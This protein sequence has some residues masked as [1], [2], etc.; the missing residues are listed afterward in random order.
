LEK[1]TGTVNK[2]TVVISTEA[3]G[4]LIMAIK[5][6][7]DDSLMDKIVRTLKCS[8]SAQFTGKRAGM[9][10]AG[11]QGLSAEQLL[12]IATHDQD[13]DA[14][15]TELRLRASRFLGSKNRDHI[16]GAVFLSSSSLRPAVADIQDSGGTA[17]NFPKRESPFWSDE[18]SGLFG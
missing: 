18:F 16:V 17:Y 2:E 9:M 13:P 10:V 14:A 7:E 12:N 6:K 8:A 4:A 5:S 1:L 11:F 15:P 3:G